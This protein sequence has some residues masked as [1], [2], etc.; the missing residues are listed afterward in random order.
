MSARISPEPL[1]RL[2]YNFDGVI[3]SSYERFLR[4]IFLENRKKKFRKKFHDFFFLQKSSA[5]DFFLQTFFSRN[6]FSIFCTILRWV[7]ASGASGVGGVGER[8]EPPAG[9]LAV[10]AEG[11]VNSEL[12]LKN[13][14]NLRAKIQHIY[15]HLI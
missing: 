6:I 12:Q 4:K 14:L 1:N 13:H 2:S 3:Y 7:G 5:L 11:Y 15:I 10:G 8:S 9:G